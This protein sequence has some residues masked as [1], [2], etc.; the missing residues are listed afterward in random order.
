MQLSDEQIEQFQALYFKQYGKEL[1]KQDAMEQASKLLRLVM[2][3]YRPMSVEDFD[4][5]QTRR[6]NEMP[7]II[8]RIARQESGNSL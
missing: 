7:K 2:L 6:L 1:N 8:S 3:I 4:A 5:I